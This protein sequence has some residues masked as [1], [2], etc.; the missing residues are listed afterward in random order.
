M[1]TTKTV[2]IPWSLGEH[3]DLVYTQ[4]EDGSWISAPH[5]WAWYGSAL[6]HS[7]LIPEFR[8]SEDDFE[9]DCAVLD[10][11][12]GILNGVI[13]GSFL[14]E[15]FAQKLFGRECIELPEEFEG[16]SSEYEI[17]E[18]GICSVLRKR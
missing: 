10:L 16:L 3:K 18:G 6:G 9:N 17:T 7:Y 4:R 12:N 1:A 15:L 13:T 11:Y 5:N 14:S 8:E 2:S